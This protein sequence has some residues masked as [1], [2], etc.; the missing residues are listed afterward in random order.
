M[1][2]YDEEGTFYEDLEGNDYPVNPFSD[3]GAT[4]EEE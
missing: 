2:P 1:I 4:I 3:E